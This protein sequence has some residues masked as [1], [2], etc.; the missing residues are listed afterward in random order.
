MPSIQLGFNTSTAVIIILLI[1]ASAT[2]ALFYR[3]TLPPIPRGKRILLTILRAA[4]LSLVLI[5]LFEPLLHLVVSSVQRPTLAV[6]VDNS[7]S[8]QIKDKVG[9]RAEQLTSLIG[10]EALQA[11]ART[12]ALRYYTFGIKPKHVDIL[13]KDSLS[14]SEDATDISAALLALAE[15]KGGQNITAALLL[16]DGSYNLGQNPVY[17]AELLGLPLYTV[18]IGDSSEQKD[19]LVT[20]V[21]TND[22]VFS[23]SEVPV[24]VTVKGSGFNGQRVEVTLSE[25]T[26]ELSRASLVL[27]EGTRE[28][29]V[30]LS[31]VPQGEGTKKYLVKVSTLGGELTLTNNRKTFFAKVLKSKLRVIMIAGAPGPD[32]SIVKQTL[33]EDKNLDVRSFTQR[34]PSGFYEGTLTSASLDSADCVV[35]IGFPTSQTTSTVLDLVRVAVV[36]KNKPLLF[37]NGKAVDESKL[38]ALNSVLPFV[39]ASQRSTVEQYVFFQPA[40]AQKKHPILNTGA[41]EDAAAW[42]KLP[43]IFKTQT[44]YRA[45]TEATTLGFVRILNVPLQEP[46]VAFRNVNRQKSLAVLGYGIWRWRLM[47]RGTPETE[48]LLSIFLSNSI[49]WLT[50]HEDNRPVK[51]STTKELYTQGEPVEF[52]AQ[53]YDASANPV[54]N[55]QVRVTAQQEGKEFE[56]TLTQ[57]G[58]G[59]Y[60]GKIDGLSEGDYTFRTAAQADGQP[61]GEDQG[62]FTVGELNLEF[63]DPRMNTSLLR[64]L[65]FRTSGKYYSPENIKELVTDIA[66]LQSFKARDIRRATAYEIWNWQYTLACIVLLFGMEW[67]IRKRSGML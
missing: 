23:E 11:I 15:E 67:F 30:R 49:R 1:V 58:N 16:T 46:L 5:L 63:Q 45:K 24:D 21:S 9:D 56:T 22:L 18:G 48:K 37:I 50:T 39:Q 26:R 66:S 10:S 20:K 17:E 6:L 41:G 57:I 3:Y 12:G 44:S 28:Y 25:G 53:V 59:R 7:K 19:I 62:R 40:D 64:E 33:I 31:Y 38:Q 27:G 61:L 51:G 55:A 54:D 8:M 34:Q 65:A 35:L 36:Q 32:L 29:P 4:A 14:L 47:A 52:T 43:P 60:E 13:T 42:N 2:A